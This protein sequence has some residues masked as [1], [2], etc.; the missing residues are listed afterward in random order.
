[1]SRSDEIGTQFK[2]L[3]QEYIELDLPVAK[4]IGIRCTSPLILGKHIVHHTTSIFIRQI[5]RMERNI[6]PPGHQFGKDPIIVPGT[7]PLQGSGRIVPVDHEESDYF[8]PLLLEE[9]RSDR[10]IDTPGKS[11]YH[12]CHLFFSFLLL[13]YSLSDKI[14]Q[15][16]E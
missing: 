9:P 3:L 12:S 10:R 4:H 1:M 7:I 6:E 2:C 13:I 14:L 5:D 15:R 16:T 8:M 11:H